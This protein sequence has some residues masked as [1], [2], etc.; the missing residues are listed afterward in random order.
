M[1]NV[2]KHTR[3]V[4]GKTISVKAHYRRGKSSIIPSVKS[5]KDEEYNEYNEVINKSFEQWVKEYG[6]IES[7]IY[8][9][10]FDLESYV[11][12]NY[13]VELTDDDYDK[14]EKEAIE[15]YRHQFKTDYSSWMQKYKQFKFPLTLYREVYSDNPRF[16]DI[17]VYWSDNMD[18]AE[19]HWGKEGRQMTIQTKVRPSDIDWEGT[20]GINMYPS[21]G[22][23]E[24]EIRL[25]KGIPIF[26][27]RVFGTVDEETIMTSVRATT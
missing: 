16:K 21:L 6:G 25:K 11:Y 15:N 17:G 1:V 9:Y 8:G 5:I 10:D 7:L 3:K 24:Q 27:S 13:D 4:K 14:C 18:C 12:G 20:L 2:R 26:V 22:Q 19:A 23:D